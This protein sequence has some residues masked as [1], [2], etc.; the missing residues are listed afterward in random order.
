MSLGL[1]VAVVF[2]VVLL[3]LMIVWI[4]GLAS[5]LGGLTDDLFQQAQQRIRDTFQDSNSNFAVWPSQYTLPP[6]KSLIMAAGMKN[7]APDGK[8]HEFVVNVIPTQS[9]ACTGSFS[10]CQGPGGLTMDQYM[11]SWLT[12]DGNPARGLIN[13]VLYSSLTISVP[14]NSPK[15]T[16]IFKAISCYDLA[17]PVPDYT[18][19]LPTSPETVLLSGA[20]SITIIVA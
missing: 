5:S 16:Y 7:N 19:C 10:S 2:A 17:S 13:E 6:G 3:S 12:F 4:Q 20:Q 8:S 9:S 11:R 1:I 15:G 14:D 18:N